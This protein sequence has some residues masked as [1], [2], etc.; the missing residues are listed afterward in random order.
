MED[1]FKF[2]V[3]IYRCYY[4][5]PYPFKWSGNHMYHSFQG[6]EQHNAARQIQLISKIEKIWNRADIEGQ[7][8]E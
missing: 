8:V 1:A 3:Y 4:K 5:V 7:E 6:K 2:C